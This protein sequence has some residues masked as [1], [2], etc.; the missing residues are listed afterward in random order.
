MNVEANQREFRN[1]TLSWD[2]IKPQPQIL[3]FGDV[4][5]RLMTSTMELVLHYSQE[6]DGRPH[7]DSF[8]RIAEEAS[9]HDVVMYA[10]DH[11]IFLPGLKETV[12]LVASQFDR[13]LLMGRRWDI[14][15][16]GFLDFVGGRWWQEL[17]THMRGHKLG[18][19]GAKDWLIWRKPFPEPIP[20]FI[21]G[22]PWYDTWMAV[23]AE[24]LGI[25]RID[26]SATV[27]AIHPIHGF[28]FPGGIVGRRDDP[29]YAYNESLAPGCAHRGHITDSEWVVVGKP[30][31]PILREREDYEG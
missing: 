3:V 4:P 11:L 22:I 23:Q 12:E 21:M 14:N 5:T 17:L 31:R 15:I 8:I 2:Q 1:A 9:I 18:S 28:P 13:F 10:T 19:V 30:G 27:R 29:R 16:P 26:A 25:Q 24:E 6:P 20:P 7:F